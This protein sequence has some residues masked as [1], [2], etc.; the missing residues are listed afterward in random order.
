MNFLK[1]GSATCPPISTKPSKP[2][3]EVLVVGLGCFWGP[4]PRYLALDGVSRCVVGYAGGHEPNPTYKRMKDYTEC[5][6]VEFD[7]D[8]V[9]FEDLLI[10]FGRMHSPT[11]SWTRQY[12][13]VIFY[14]NEEQKEQAEEFLDGLRASSRGELYTKIEPMSKFYKAEEYHQNYITKASGKSLY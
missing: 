4:Q 13:S 14:S 9:T 6:L 2:S 8:V 11:S 5:V 3:N 1:H 12:R 10:E 7:P